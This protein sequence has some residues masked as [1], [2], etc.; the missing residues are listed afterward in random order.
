MGEG[1]GFQD[2]AEQIEHE[3]Q[4]EG[5]ENESK[6]EEKDQKP[7]SKKDKDKGFDME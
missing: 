1:Q 2:V 7:D 6:Q 4:L 5:L 3:E